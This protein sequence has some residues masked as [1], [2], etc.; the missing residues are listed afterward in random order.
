[1]F[2]RR[3]SP[4]YTNIMDGIFIYTERLNLHKILELFALFID[5]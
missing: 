1:M 3:H 5:I 2:T 4:M